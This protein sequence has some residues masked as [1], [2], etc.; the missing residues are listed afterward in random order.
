MF[1]LR[2]VAIYFPTRLSDHCLRGP[3]RTLV[4]GERWQP[5]C[6][7][8]TGPGAER[9]QGRNAVAAQPGIALLAPG[10]ERRVCVARDIRSLRGRRRHAHIDQFESEIGDPLH[11]S[12][13]G[14]EMIW[15][16][17]TKASS[18]PGPR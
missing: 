1:R 15:Q 3:S 14:G 7:V 8:K 11:D 6:S 16:P 18:F 4:T 5:A 2:E 10:P 12:V 13:E 17:G 9:C